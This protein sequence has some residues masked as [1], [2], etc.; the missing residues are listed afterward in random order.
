MTENP[1]V[2]SIWRYPVKS[3]AGEELEAVPVSKRG[4]R[5]DRAYALVDNGTNHV[6]SAKN[7]KRF[8]EL[9]KWQVRFIAA[10]QENAT[11][12]PIIMTLPDGRT[13]TSSD[14]A[15]AAQLA[16]IFGNGVLLESSATEGL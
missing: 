13:L 8:G 6:G 9:L 2:H 12:P 5:G 16:E 11:P 15:T 3:M 14:P 10:P 7:A 4:V 1:T